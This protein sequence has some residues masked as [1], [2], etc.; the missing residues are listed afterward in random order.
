VHPRFL[1]SI[2]IFVLIVLVNAV[3]ADIAYEA[4]IKGGYTDNLYND[5]SGKNDSYSTTRLSTNLYPIANVEV[6]LAGEYTY[7]SNSFNLSN[8]FYS[9]K[10]TYIPTSEDLPYSVYL[11]ANFDRRNYRKKQE[12]FDN[13]NLS[14]TAS[15][16][17]Y[18]LPQLQVRTGSKITSTKYIKTTNL[19]ADYEQY[20]LFGGLNTSFFGSNSFDI[21]VGLGTM[22]FSFINAH[23]QAIN[24]V[25]PGD[26]LSTG[27]LYQIYLSPRFSRPLGAKTGM[28]IAYTYRDF[29]NHDDVVIF[30]FTTGFLSP[31]ASVYDGSSVQLK[32]KSYL[33]P[34]SIIKGGLGYWDKTYLKSLEEQKFGYPSPKNAPKR[35]DY[36]TRVF[37]SFQRPIVFGVGG[38]LEPTVSLDYTHNVS[39]DDRYDYNGLTVTVNMVYRR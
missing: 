35:K 16:G 27:Q 5:S 39:S 4:S 12:E 38:V 26:S 7:Y 29:T 15:F 30:G 14:L 2:C 31:W 22:N 21:E 9:G 6:N 24:P 13:Q 37:A 34:H 18:L 32:L 23:V 28:S 1:L 8:L 10:V 33:I 20:E 25:N 19:D 36:L 3:Q 11:S 17:Y